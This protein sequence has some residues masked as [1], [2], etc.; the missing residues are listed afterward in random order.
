[1]QY[2][3]AFVRFGFGLQALVGLV[4]LRVAPSMVARRLHQGILPLAI[5]LLAGTLLFASLNLIPAI[6]WWTL[7]RRERSA[8]VWAIVA[9]VVN[10]AWSPLVARCT[11]S[12]GMLLA[13]IG[14]CGLAAFVARPRV[15]LN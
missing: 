7:G 8:R 14:I 6:A 5:T 11:E 9:S 12:G 3:A 4:T 2:L 13:L 15:V 10:I 1:V